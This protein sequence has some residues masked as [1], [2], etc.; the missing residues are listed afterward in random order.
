MKQAETF[1]IEAAFSFTES[2]SI[3][4]LQPRSLGYSRTATALHLQNTINDYLKTPEEMD[5]DF[6]LEMNSLK[7]HLRDL[8]T[9]PDSE[10]RLT[11]NYNNFFLNN[12][13]SGFMEE[14]Y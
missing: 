11:D 4:D 2:K 12:T 8:H 1:K 13:H 5:V 10:G 7:T 3:A 14:N 9:S 6:Y